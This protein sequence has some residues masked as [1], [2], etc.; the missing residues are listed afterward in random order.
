MSD[1]TLA[2]SFGLGDSTGTLRFS[3]RDQLSDRDDSEAWGRRWVT[4]S[5]DSGPG[6]SGDGW[7]GGDGGSDGGGGFGGDGGGGGSGGGDGGGGGGGGG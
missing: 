5:S 3:A 2:V 6:A 7:G 4:G 1:H